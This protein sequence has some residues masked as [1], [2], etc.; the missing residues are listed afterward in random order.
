MTAKNSGVDIDIVSYRDLEKVSKIF[1]NSFSNELHPEHIKQ[2]IRR[3]RQFYYLLR[4]LARLSPRIKNLFN[5]YTIKANA[6]IA[7]FLQVSY[8]NRKQLH[9]DY[10][11]ISKKYQ[12]QG[13]GTLVLQKLINKVAEHGDFDIVLEVK[14]DNT[15]YHLYK[16]FGFATRTRILHYEK[17]LSNA[18]MAIVDLKIS[19]LRKIQDIDRP[20][21]YK[22]YKH[23]IPKR[24]QYVIQREYRHFNP[25]LFVRQLDWV[26]NRLMRI[27]KREYVVER[28]G[29]IIASLEIRSCPH[30]SDHTINLMIHQDHDELRAP[31]I[32]YA[33]FIV[34]RNYGNGMINTTIY[35]DNP[36][37]QQILER[38][39]FIHDSTYFLMV[40]PASLGGY[41][42]S[43]S[44]STVS[45]SK[46]PTGVNSRARSS[47]QIRH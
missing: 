13:L 3:I 22:L 29:I 9:L 5:I 45:K 39:G 6:N 32:K 40:R 47:D 11:A 43:M 42:F 16:R 31:L 10:I 17:S 36:R 41:H 37:K 28:N 23:S 44:P 30:V 12:G 20:Q 27:T 38:L 18:D 21:L 7:G 8:L 4:P 19:G 15:A 33:F 35:D 25:S 14:S 46:F 24:I 26:K 1:A 34:S 2:R